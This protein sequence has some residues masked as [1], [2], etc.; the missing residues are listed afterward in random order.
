MAN[1]VKMITFD[2]TNTILRVLGGVGQQYAQISKLYGV[3]LDPVKINQAF[4]THWARQNQQHPNFGAEENMAS[5]H[6]WQDL[7]KKTFVDAGYQGNDSTISTIFTHLY[8]HFGTSNGWE[9]LP[10]A[11]QTLQNLK[12][13]GVKLGVISNFDERLETIL[14]KIALKHHFDFVISSK[15][16][17]IAKPD[18][19][20]F[21]E[22]LRLGECPACQSLHVG[23]HFHND[24]CGA[25][26]AGLT[27]VLYR[28]D[29]NNLPQEV[30]KHYVVSNLDELSRYL[31]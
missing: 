15:E 25:R 22:A 30:D 1:P 10:G 16:F 26:E 7:V 14:N 8:I 4:K 11:D 2:V 28:K 18:V 31:K 9:V 13:S 3:E 29:M 24:Y 20:I 23:D 12:N 17:K 5:H 19:R 6:W 21:Q 27:G